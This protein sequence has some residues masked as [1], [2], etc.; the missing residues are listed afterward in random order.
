[1]TKPQQ[2]A[3]LGVHLLRAGWQHDPSI[4]QVNEDLWGW[5]L[6]FLGGYSILTL[7]CTAAKHASILCKGVVDNV[8]SVQHVIHKSV[9]VGSQNARLHF[10]QQ[11]SVPALEEVIRRAGTALK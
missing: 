3:M 2:K 9:G 10:A 4:C 11:Q 5:R 6:T 7:A 1:M 8:D